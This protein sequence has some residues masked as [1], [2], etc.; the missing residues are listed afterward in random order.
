MAG[1]P[2]IQSQTAVLP[3]SVVNQYNSMATGTGPDGTINTCDVIGLAIDYNNFAAEFVSAANAISAMPSSADLTALITAYQDM[4]GASNNTEM[5]TYIDDA[6][7]AIS[8]IANSSTHPEYVS[9]VSSLNLSFNNMASILSKEKQYQSQAGIDYF[10]IQSG[11][12]SVVYAFVQALPGYGLEVGPCGPAYFL[13]QVADISVIGGQAIVGTMREATNN[14]RLNG[15]QLGVD[16][17]PSS[18]LAVTPVPAITP[19]Y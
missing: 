3:A 16:T 9:Y 19:V 13:N 7:A 2:D 12:K 14:Q 15:S 4:L 8:A 11:D 10:S 17:A 1:L 6:N 5:Q 18:T